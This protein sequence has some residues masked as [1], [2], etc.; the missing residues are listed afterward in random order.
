MKNSVLTIFFFFTF[1]SFV[2]GQEVLKTDDGIIL[3]SNSERINELSI[4]KLEI[5]KTKNSE[6]IISHTGYSLLYNEK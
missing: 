3:N 6:K 1:Q 5:P 4:P 2:F